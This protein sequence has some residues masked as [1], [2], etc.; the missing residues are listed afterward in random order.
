MKENVDNHIEK[1]TDKLFKEMPL[2]IPSMDF[3]TNVMSQVET[4]AES[5][6]TTYK[7]LISKR[8]WMG[9][10]VA[11]V[12]VLV[13]SFYGSAGESEFFKSLNL[14]IVSDNKL[15]SVLSNLSFSKSIIYAATMFVIMFM[16]QVM[17]LKGY[18]NKRLSV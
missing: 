4:I 10:A 13:Y 1:I 3:T 16:I 18:F 2:E 11:I 9:I 5:D 6:I 8:V 14:S 7:P 12:G 17:V 15:V